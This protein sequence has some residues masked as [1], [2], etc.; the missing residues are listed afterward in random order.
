MKSAK[1]S[2]VI[3]TCNGEKYIEEQLKSIL[4]QTIKSNEIIICDDNSKDTTVAIIKKVLADVKVNYKL[5]V[6]EENLGVTKNFEKAIKMATGDII[7]FSDQDDIWKKEKIEELTKL[8]NNPQCVVAYSDAEILKENE[9]SKKTLWNIIGFSPDNDFKYSEKLLKKSLITGAT[10][11]VRKSFLNEI[12]PF[13]KEWIH[14]G[15][16][17]INAEI[18]GEINCTDKKLMQYRI[19]NSNV[20]GV[21]SDIADKVRNYIRNTKILVNERVYRYQRYKIFYKR[22]LH[23]LDLNY[24]KRLEMCIDFWNDMV[25]IKKNNRIKG[26]GL[27]LKN[28]INGNYNRFYTG[29]KG[30]IRDIVSVFII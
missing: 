21:S 20:I 10:M 17:A 15:W 6:N 18:Y 26:L 28:L 19:H 1:I 16:I 2:T 4:N 29:I 14:D 30:A 22:K 8:F 13:P 9:I 3:C 7:F 24:E 23:L 12:L 27:V 5:I 11:A 25:K